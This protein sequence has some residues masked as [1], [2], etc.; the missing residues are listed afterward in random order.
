[1]HGTTVP[2]W[3]VTEPGYE[4]FAEHLVRSKPLPTWLPWP[5]PPGWQVTDFGCVVS[6]GE[7]PQAAF[8]TASGPSVVDG[9]VEVTVLTEEPGVGLGARCASVLHTDPG[10]EAVEG[11][12]A[13]RLRVDGATVPVW[14]VPT[15]DE[16][17]LAAPVPEQGSQ[18]LLDR[19]VL[20]GESEGRWLWVVVRPAA[21]ALLLLRGLHLQDVSELGPALLELPFGALPRAW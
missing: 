13:L 4:P 2:L 15:A 5:I 9:I 16:P 19:T 1:L 17:R 18:P 20:V 11:A 10:R 3:R 6:E 8:A 7:R 14:A 12:P 21:A